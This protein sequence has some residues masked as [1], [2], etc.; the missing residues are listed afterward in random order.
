[1]AFEIY[2]LSVLKIAQVFSGEADGLRTWEVYAV[3]VEQLGDGVAKFIH[4]WFL[5]PAANVDKIWDGAAH[6]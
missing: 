5:L 4:V 2:A 6:I 1:M 3:T